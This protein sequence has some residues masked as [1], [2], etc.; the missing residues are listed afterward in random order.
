MSS[1]PKKLGKQTFSFGKPYQEDQLSNLNALASIGIPRVVRVSCWIIFISLVIGISGLWIPWVQTTSGSGQVTTLNPSDRVQSISALV[2][3]R[4]AEWYVQD[5]DYVEAGDPIIRIQDIDDQLIVRLQLQLDAARR[6]IEASQEAVTTAQIDYQRQKDL[7]AEGLASQLSFEQAR[8]KVQQMTV[9]LE[10]ARSEFNQAE[11]ALSR[12]GSQLVVAPRNGTI[13]HVEAGDT[14][15]IVSAGQPLATFMPADTE[16]A[17]EIMIDG[18]DIGL[19]HPGRQVRLQFEGWPAFQFSGRPDLAVGTFR[20]EVVFV[21]PSARLDGRFRVLV[22]EPLN[23][24]DCLESEVI[25]G[26]PRMGECGWPPE[27]FVRLGATVRGWILLE[28]VPLGFELWRL[29]NSFPPINV[30]NASSSEEA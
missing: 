9:S 28:T 4:I 21:E 2:T 6:K 22:K 27:S 30:T 25:N 5:A 29:L 19:V 8:I 7:F 20:G 18:R 16:R 11:T 12:Q 10:E 15:T 1:S 26:I 23:S 24:E 14:A 13:I 3:G 17:V